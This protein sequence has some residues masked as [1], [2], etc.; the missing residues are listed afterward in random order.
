MGLP[1]PIDRVS[2]D[3]LMSLVAERG[4]APML[5]GAVLLLD[6]A[7]LDGAA[8]IEQLG[9]R[10]AA[11]PRLRQRLLAVPAGCGRPVW[12]PDPEFSI[13]RHVTAVQLPGRSLP[14]QAVLDLAAGMLTTPLPRDRPLWAGTLVTSAEGGDAALIVV[15]HHVL[16][17]GVGGMAVLGALVDGRDAAA[18]DLP[19]S[20]PTTGQIAFDALLLRL[21]AVGRL[22]HAVLRLGAAAGHLRGAVGRRL[23]RTSLNVPTG[24]RRELASIRLPLAGVL[25]AARAQGATV[26]DVLLVATAAAL[27]RLVAGRGEWIDDVVLSVPFSSRREASASRL[28]NQSGVVPLRIP[29]TG[30]AGERLRRVAGLTRAA[31]RGTRGA[32]TALLGPL[33]R[34]LARLGLYRRFINRQRLI[35]SFVSNVRGPAGPMS[36]FGCPITAVLPLGTISG[37]VTVAFTALSYA[38]TLAITVIADPDACGDLTVLEDALRRELAV[39]TGEETAAR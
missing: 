27:R 6:A 26:N 8:A 2:S 30:D 7:G 24:P 19:A 35:H 34:L 22:P 18:E 3:D 10:A 28:G 21:R 32:S 38:G 1:A 15:L 23:A 9:H 17:D 14:E 4:S 11:V 39:L 12:V 31:K 13:H 33:F 29:A 5:V 37:N 36:V 16:A 25:A 20:H